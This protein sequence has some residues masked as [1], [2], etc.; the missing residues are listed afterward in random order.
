M[1]HHQ[2]HHHLA[3][4]LIKEETSGLAKQSKM[5]MKKPWSDVERQEAIWGQFGFLQNEEKRKIIMHP[6]NLD[7]GLID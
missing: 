3:S 5:E 7:S 1:R 4:N 2:R 6:A